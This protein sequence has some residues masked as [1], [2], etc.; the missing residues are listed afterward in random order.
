MISLPYGFNVGFQ[1]RLVLPAGQTAHWLAQYLEVAR[2]EAVSRLGLP[3]V[4]LASRA[5]KLDVVVLT[6]LHQ[7]HGVHVRGVGDVDAG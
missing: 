4:V 2:C 7:K 3:Q 1:F 5:D 6:G